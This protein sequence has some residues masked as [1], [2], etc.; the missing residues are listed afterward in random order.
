MR[1][2]FP[3]QSVISHCGPLMQSDFK[4]ITLKNLWLL[5]INTYSLK[6]ESNLQRYYNIL[7]FKSW[8]SNKINRT[9]DSQ[10]KWNTILT[11]NA[12]EL[13]YKIEHIKLK[14]EFYNDI[15]KY[16]NTKWNHGKYFL[17]NKLLLQSIN[18]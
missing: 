16:K 11:V 7:F 15:Y 8:L 13:P 17:P 6:T 2:R 14:K 10:Y 18:Q 3:V 9:Y 5:G 12:F 1:V 4:E